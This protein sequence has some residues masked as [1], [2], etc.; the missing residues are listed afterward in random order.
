MLDYGRSGLKNFLEVRADYFDIVMA[1]RPHDME[2]FK[3]VYQS[4]AK[5]DARPK[6]VY[7]AEAFVAERERALREMKGK[8]MPHE[9]F[10]RRVEAEVGIANGADLVFAV[11]RVGAGHLQA[12][13]GIRSDQVLGHALSCNPTEREYSERRDILFVGNLDE[14]ESPN[15]DS[16]WW[17]A[18][19]VLP[20]VRHVL[21][22]VQLNVVGSCRSGRVRQLAGAYVKLHGRVNDLRAFY[23]TAR[24][25]VAPTR[26]AAGIPYKVHD[27]AA[28]GVP[29][30]LTDI[31]AAQLGWT[32][33][34]DALVAEDGCRQRVRG[35]VRRTVHES[36]VMGK[37]PR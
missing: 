3:K 30:V 7:D 13:R 11:T 26:Y 19:K 12:G 32:S 8:S 23:E 2:F 35:R 15:A 18:E 1:S 22:D 33:K 10:N 21:G 34:Q 17:F 16:L 6:I 27:A 20:D 36:T 4:A 28:H 24:I 14:D 25:F 5:G 9:F 31:L 29:A 37:R